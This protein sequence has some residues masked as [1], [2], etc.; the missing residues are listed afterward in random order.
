MRAGQVIRR[1][2]A[3]PAISEGGD[4]ALA[5]AIVTAAAAWMCFATKLPPLTQY[6]QILARFA[7]LSGGGH[8][9]QLSAYYEQIWRL[10]PNL[11]LDA[12][13]WVLAPFCDVHTLGK[14][15]VWLSFTSMLAG[16][17]LLHHALHGRFSVISL[18]AGLLV[19]N[20][21]FIEGY[22]GFLLTLGCALI[23]VATW[24]HCRHWPILRLGIGLVVSIALYLGHLYAFVVYA[25][26]VLGYELFPLRVQP[27]IFK[28]VGLAALQLLPPLLLLA[29][30][31]PPLA[32]DGLFPARLPGEEPAG[33]VLIPG[34][35]VELESALLAAAALG[36][37]IAWA[38]GWAVLRLDLV[39]A[40]VLLAALYLASALLPGTWGGWPLIP[41][42][43]IALVSLDWPSATS[44]AQAMQWAA[45]AI[46]TALQLAHVTV[47]WQSS[48]PVMADLVRL[49]SLVERGAK[50]AGATVVD[51]TP[52][53]SFPPLREAVAL[54]T[55]EASA[56][57]PSLDAYP[58]NPMSTIGY[59]PAHADQAFPPPDLR[60]A[61][62]MPARELQS[63]FER[64]L[65]EVRNHGYR[66]LLLIDQAGSSLRLP[67]SL[68]L[69]EATRDGRG[70]L[71]AIGE[72]S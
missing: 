36:L 49:A 57:V 51:G 11:A 19:I 65:D 25:V 42:A 50:I 9:A 61:P 72:T 55:V 10:Q 67:A 44:R 35:Q 47:Q 2:A 31:Q 27:H 3:V 60:A 37:G 33:F 29:V 1:R 40:G 7:I 52:D 15:T 56:L 46:L 64:Y 43:V 45:F 70:R 26:C 30:L 12:L 32:G 54:F 28:R 21:Y 6:P 34:Y 62:G 48:D 18:L 59:R 5:F 66:Y 69:I 20:R 41:T 68:R 22:L 13:A 39:I 14:L 53:G 58:L 23:G 8:D 38:L 16:C 4:V 24:M 71:L 63:R 17:V